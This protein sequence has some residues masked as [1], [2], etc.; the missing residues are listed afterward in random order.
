MNKL[1][2][3]LFIST[4]S[5]SSYGATNDNNKDD[6]STMGTSE[7]PQVQRQQSRTDKGATG[8]N[9]DGVKDDASTL[10]TSETPQVQ[11]QQNRTDKGVSERPNKN[12]AKNKVMR[13][14]EKNA[15]TTQGNPIQP[16][17]PEAAPPATN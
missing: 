10:G 17:E 11:K 15:G 4:L 12:K 2:L 3:A 9:Q 13:E 1:L 16:T 14:K 5:I 6:G 7:T 8:V